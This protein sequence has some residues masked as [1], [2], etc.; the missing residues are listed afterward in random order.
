MFDF[1]ALLDWFIA[2]TFSVGFDLIGSTVHIVG[3]R[4]T[5]KMLYN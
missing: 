5:N 3:D 1:L 2:F 4:D